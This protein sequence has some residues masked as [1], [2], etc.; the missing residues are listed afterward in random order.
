MNTVYNNKVG[1]GYWTTL[2][3]LS[4]SSPTHVCAFILAPAARVVRIR[5]LSVT[6]APT[7]YYKPYSHYSGWPVQVWKRIR[8][9][10]G[11]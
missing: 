6:S 5:V 3:Y 4:Q 9:W 10:R 2:H 8:G 7:H 1:A 11:L